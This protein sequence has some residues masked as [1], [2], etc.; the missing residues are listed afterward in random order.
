MD[1]IHQLPICSRAVAINTSTPSMHAKMIPPKHTK[2][3][4]ESKPGCLTYRSCGTPITWPTRHNMHVLQ[5]SGHS[6]HRGCH[7]GS[8]E[9]I[10]EN[11]TKY[12]LSSGEDFCLSRGTPG[13]DSRT[14][15]HV[16]VVSSRPDNW[17]ARAPVR[18]PLGK[19]RILVSD[20]DSVR[21]H[22][23]LKTPK[24]LVPKAVK[25]FEVKFKQFIAWEF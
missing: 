23:K 9:N 3:K 4:R 13:F 2:F 20:V 18:L 8:V 24:F 6:L 12:A 14:M 10:K 22:V 25:D 1:S 16:H 19:P 5:A 17:R 21:W 15:H 11:E 7:C